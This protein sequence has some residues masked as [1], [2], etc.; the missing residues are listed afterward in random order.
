M[1]LLKYSQMSFPRSKTSA[2]RVNFK[3]W[4]LLVYRNLDLSHCI[5][6]FK[7][8][9]YFKTVEFPEV[10][11]IRCTVLISG[12]NSVSATELG[13]KK[14]IAK[15]YNFSFSPCFLNN[16]NMYF[17]LMMGKRDILSFWRHI[18]P[19]VIEA[20]IHSS[21]PDSCTYKRTNIWLPGDH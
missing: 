12:E 2:R 11:F 1:Q 10:T 7:S 16:K 6:H 5:A 21:Y 13:P 4:C 14:D 15:S 9:N 17:T 8:K 19:P 20:E 18:T 3:N